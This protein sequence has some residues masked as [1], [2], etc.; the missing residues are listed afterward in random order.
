MS[1][2]HPN[3]IGIGVEEEIETTDEH[4]QID[5]AG[6]QGH[7]KARRIRVDPCSSVVSNHSSCAHSGF[8]LGQK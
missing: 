7:T 1:P 5:D 8:L 2:Y 4:R 3:P 6:T